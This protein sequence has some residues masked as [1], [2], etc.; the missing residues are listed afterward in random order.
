MSRIKQLEVKALEAQKK[1]IQA[2]KALKT[3]QSVAAKKNAAQ[4]RKDDTRRKII[5]GGFMLNK[6]KKDADIERY[7]GEFL[8]TL[9]KTSDRRLFDLKPLPESTNNI[10]RPKE[11][12]Q[13]I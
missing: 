13:A 3:A 10:P 6:V 5:F 2:R 1:A 7:F 11:V 8:R 12:N 9:T 4:K